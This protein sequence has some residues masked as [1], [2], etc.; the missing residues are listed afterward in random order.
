MSLSLFP[1]GDTSVPPKH[2][3]SQAPMTVAN[4]VVF[5]A[6]MD[7]KGTLFF[8]D[9]ATGK[10]LGRFET[11]ATSG[12]GPSVVGGRVFVGSGYLNLNLGRPGN[13]LYAL[14]VV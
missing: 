6:S 7:A 4:G 9:A 5:Y 13:K 2:A 8:L 12:S 11:G 3:R 14:Q 1:A 10:M